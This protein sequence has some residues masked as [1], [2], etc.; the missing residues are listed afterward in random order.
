MRPSMS[1]RN[2]QRMVSST[3]AA[4]PQEWRDLIVERLAP[5][6]PVRIF[7][8][9]SRARGDGREVS[10]VDLLVVLERGNGSDVQAELLR[11]LDGVPFAKDVIAATPEQMEER[12]DAPGLIYRKALREGTVIYGVDERDASTWIRYARED[13]DAAELVA[14]RPGFAPRVACYNAQQAAEK[15]FKAL[16]VA[17]GQDVILTHDLRVLRDLVAPGSRAAKLDVDLAWLSGWQIKGRYPGDWGEA[18]E[19][20]ARAA[21]AAARAVVDAAEQDLRS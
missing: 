2:L 7:V 21:I 9:G 10:D 16:L 6:R 18:T 3:A 4:L 5:F 1:V 20:D 17:E 15:A 11:A 19:A 13:L 12:G 14:G 8:F